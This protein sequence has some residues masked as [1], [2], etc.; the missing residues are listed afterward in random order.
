M[1]LEKL[2]KDFHASLKFI[3]WATVQEYE[4]EK[5]NK[6]K[7]L[8]EKE[9]ILNELQDKMRYYQ[10]AYKKVEILQ[11]RRHLTLVGEK[12]GYREAYQTMLKII[13]NKY[14]PNGKYTSP[15]VMNSIVSTIEGIDDLCKDYGIEIN[16]EAKESQER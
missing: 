5:G 10:E 14:I 6:D 12:G 3:Y 1:D 9:L 13:E 15:E 11:E 7:L 16:K 8:E 4:K 2:C